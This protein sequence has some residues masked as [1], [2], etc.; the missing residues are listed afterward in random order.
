[1]DWSLLRNSAPVMVPP[2]IDAP[3]MVLDV[4]VPDR[5]SLPDAAS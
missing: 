1:M 5:L 4:I 2:V 3:V